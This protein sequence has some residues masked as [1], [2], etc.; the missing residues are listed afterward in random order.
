MP[1]FNIHEAKTH[2]SRLV[3]DA[4]AG[5]EVVIAKAGK[6][7]AKLVSIHAGGS[8]KKPPRKLGILGGKYKIPDDF[9][10]PL[11]DEV[12]AEFETPLFPIQK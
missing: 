2:F 10:G 6:P 11:P 5:K 7:V 9:D 8:G 3:D 1:T 12:L 4:A